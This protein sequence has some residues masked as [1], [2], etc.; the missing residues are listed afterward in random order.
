MLK[1]LRRDS[2]SVCKEFMSKIEIIPDVL[3]VFFGWFIRGNE[4]V[5]KDTVGDP[6]GCVDFNGT[7]ALVC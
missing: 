3:L 1:K 5:P 2:E 7:C 6:A 4:M